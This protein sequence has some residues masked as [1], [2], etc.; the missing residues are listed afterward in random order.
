MPVEWQ[1]PLHHPWLWRQSRQRMFVT[2]CTTGVIEMP[3]LGSEDLEACYLQSV[4]FSHVILY[5]SFSNKTH[6]HEPICSFRQ[7]GMC[8]W[9]FTRYGGIE[10]KKSQS[11][12]YENSHSNGGTERPA[13]DSSLTS[14][15]MEAHVK[16]TTCMKK[17]VVCLQEIIHLHRVCHLSVYHIPSTRL[18]LLEAIY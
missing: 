4:C 16:L 15:A 13:S 10:T 5:P 1:K 14:A 3:T 6:L 17:G 11:L 9:H 8:A 18:C 7:M 2:W 12:S